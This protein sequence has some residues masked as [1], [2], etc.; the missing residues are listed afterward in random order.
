MGLQASNNFPDIDLSKSLIVGNTISD[1]QFGRNLG[2]KTIF[3]PT[4]RPEVNIHDERIDA[5]Y[6]SL[7]AFATDL[8]NQH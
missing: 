4:T 8:K 7:L 2:V 6:G 3:L 1:M 5:V